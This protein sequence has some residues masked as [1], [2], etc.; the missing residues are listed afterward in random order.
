MAFL[1]ALSDPAQA[2]SFVAEE[3]S[4]GEVQTEAAISVLHQ[5]ALRDTRA[6]AAC[7]DSSTRP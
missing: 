4:P 3:M 7:A 6:A 2:A 1:S 5:W